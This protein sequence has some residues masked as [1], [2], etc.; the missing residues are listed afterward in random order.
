MSTWGSR[1]SP[2]DQLPSA[3]VVNGKL[4]EEA[5]RLAALQ[6]QRA[7]A[8]QQ[9]WA[10]SVEV[11]TPAV[12]QQH[13]AV[14]NLAAQL[15]APAHDHDVIDATALAER[16]HAGL[17]WNEA[18][19]DRLKIHKSKL[20]FTIKGTPAQLE[21]NAT[22]KI[23]EQVMEQLLQ[24]GIR[25]I[26]NELG[27]ELP[28]GSKSEIMVS[29]MNI[30]QVHAHSP[31]AL[32]LHTP[33]RPEM[34][35]G[36]ADN[37]ANDGRGEKYAL[38]VGPNASY[39]GPPVTVVDRSGL[40]DTMFTAAYARQTLK[41][42]TNDAL[43]GYDNA[44]TALRVDHFLWEFIQMNDLI[45]KGKL[46]IRCPDLKQERLSHGQHAG[47][48]VVVM[49][50]EHMESA[51]R[52]YQEHIGSKIQHQDL[53]ELDIT[54]K[55]LDGQPF[56]AICGVPRAYNETL[57]DAYLDDLI[58]V[59]VEVELEWAYVP[60]EEAID[61][62]L[63]SHYDRVARW[64]SEINQSSCPRNNTQVDPVLMSSEA[65]AA[66]RC[67]TDGVR[68]KKCPPCDYSI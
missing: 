21:E 40:V 4:A 2:A 20:A 47:V 13:G 35:H 6:A 10:S 24:P 39:T 62:E 54:V 59:V 45:Q 48:Q 53:S 61:A 42:V 57:Q 17:S 68:P 9:Q 41:K 38:L 7:A 56:T 63:D 34:Q 23:S 3:G 11:S 50:N 66:A 14:Q 18:A 25:N 33:V 55:R 43:I 64:L 29:K 5:A 12:G 52:L 16:A 36:V 31:V 30:L 8:A 58:V 51:L 15:G 27:D 60:Q 32:T 46:K 26:D 19:D 37:G 49:P 44:H 1:Y 28:S 65:A 67:C 22:K